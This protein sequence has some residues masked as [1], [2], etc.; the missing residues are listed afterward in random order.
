MKEAIMDAYKKTVRAT[1][2][3]VSMLSS[4]EEIQTHIAYMLA[5]RFK[6]K[7]LIV[8]SEH[9]YWTGRTDTGNAQKRFE[10]ELKDHGIILEDADREILKIIAIS[11]DLYK[12]AKQE[13]VLALAIHRDRHG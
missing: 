3:G 7:A 13:L 1:D 12:K 2:F 11:N 6:D 10:E 9:D 5:E 8:V 4:Y